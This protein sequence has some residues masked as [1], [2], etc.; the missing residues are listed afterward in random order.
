MWRQI[1]PIVEDMDP[2]NCEWFVKRLGIIDQ[3]GVRNTLKGLRPEQLQFIDAFQKNQRICVLKP[4]QIGM[5]TIVTACLFWKA[6][7]SS[8]PIGTLAI[9]HEAEACGRINMMLKN[10]HRTLP[11]QIRC[12]LLKDN[13]KG[14]QFGH[15]EAMFRQLMAVV[16][17]RPERLRFRTY[18][19]Q[20]W[21]CGQRV[22]AHE[23]EIV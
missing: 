9:T 23:R 21:A 20:R 22:Q 16:G 17:A 14:I 7:T 18:T 10:F 2:H 13:M 3:Y 15:N 5:T 11:P 19:A 1:W 8:Q 12:T 6:Y 4:R